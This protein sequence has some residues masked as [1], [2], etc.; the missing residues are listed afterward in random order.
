MRKLI[1]AAL[2]IAATQAQWAYAIQTASPKPNR[3]VKMCTVQE[4]EVADAACQAF[5]EG[6][7]DA[8]A[9]YGAA[10]QLALPFC[11]PRE[12]TSA[13]LVTIYRKYLGDNH[14]LRQ[15]SAAAL[16]ISAFRAQFPCE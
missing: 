1:T 14:P 5:V 7:V 9:F 15:F 6:V 11:I 4:G 3:I 16:A 12:T 10:E 8:T 2:F 13:E